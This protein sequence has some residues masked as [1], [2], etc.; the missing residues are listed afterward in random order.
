[1]YGLGV[2]GKARYG[3]WTVKDAGAQFSGE[4]ALELT[5]ARVRQIAWGLTGQSAADAEAAVTVVAEV[6]YFGQSAVASDS[7][8]RNINGANLTGTSTVGSDSERVIPHSVTVLALSAVGA[9]EAAVTVAGAQALQAFS[10]Q[11]VNALRVR[12]SPAAVLA[13]ATLTA[14]GRG[15]YVETTP[16]GDLWSDSSSETPEYQEPQ[17]DSD[18]WTASEAETDIWTPV[19]DDA[20]NW[21]ETPING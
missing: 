3:V 6:A 2:Y 7:A 15:I 1:M 5:P 9:T 17:A 10:A 21:T 16:A 8:V 20:S 18:P 4:A 19:D 14:D 13:T 11:V 12:F